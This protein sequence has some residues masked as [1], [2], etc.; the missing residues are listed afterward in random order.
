VK[1]VSVTVRRAAAAVARRN[2]TRFDAADADHVRTVDRDDTPDP[3]EPGVPLVAARWPGRDP[4][5]GQR[6]DAG[7]L[8]KKGVDGY[9][10]PATPA[11]V[12]AWRD[13]CDAEMLAAAD[14]KPAAQARAGTAR[15]PHT[16]APPAPWTGPPKAVWFTRTRRRTR[17]LPT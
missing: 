12:A 10:T 1:G 15:D 17:T 14:R 9:W 6:Y 7:T 4:L 16:P 13:A 8:L 11:E 2:T 3:L 5:T